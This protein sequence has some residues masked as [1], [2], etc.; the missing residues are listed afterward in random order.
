VKFEVEATGLVLVGVP[1][2]IPELVNCKPAGKEPLVRVQVSDPT[3]P[4][5]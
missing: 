5:A 1:E 3:P 2:I 4:L